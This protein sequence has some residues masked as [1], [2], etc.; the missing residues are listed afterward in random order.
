MDEYFGFR[1]SVSL[2]AGEMG[3]VENLLAGAIEPHNTNLLPEKY[4]G[5]KGVCAVHLLLG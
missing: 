4:R 2:A 5:G 3:Y 1:I